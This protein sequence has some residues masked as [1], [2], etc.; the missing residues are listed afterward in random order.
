M[1]HSPL[2]I[3]KAN[4]A[5]ASLRRLKYFP[6]R[7][8]ALEDDRQVKPITGPYTHFMREIHSF[9][10]LNG[11]TVAQ[12]G[13]RLGEIWRS[14]TETE[15]NVRTEPVIAEFVYSLLTSYVS[16]RNTV[17]A[18]KPIWSGTMK[19]TE[20]NI[21]KNPHSGNRSLGPPSRALYTRN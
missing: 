1:S 21:T 16:Y 2:E 17:R 13:V 11:L 4:L 8:K 15:K 9:G 7:Y 10:E 14:L 19:N 3:R 5:R 20:N 12:C 18:M 6:R